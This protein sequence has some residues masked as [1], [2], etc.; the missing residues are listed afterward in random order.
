VKNLLR[1]WFTAADPVG[2]RAY[3][4]HGLAL[5]LVKYAV[6]AALIWAFAHVFWTPI[7]YVAA[8]LSLERSKLANVP[9]PLQLTLALWTAPFFWVGLTLS[10]RRARDAGV[11]PWIAQLFFVP[12]VN[13][14]FMAAMCL[15]PSRAG[16]IAGREADVRAEESDMKSRWRA[17]G[18]G[19]LAGLATVL[20]GIGVARSYGA[21]LFFGAPFVIG[22]VSAY[23]YNRA[24][25]ATTRETQE[26]VFLTL[27]LIA[28]A[29]LAFAIEG[30]LCAA[31]AFPFAYLIATMGAWFGRWIALN[32]TGSPSRAL[33][34]ALL[35]PAAAPLMDT[36]RAPA[37]YEV[38]SVVEVDA[39]PMAVWNHVVAFPRLPAPSDLIFRVGIAY[40]IG[41]RIVGAGIGA[42]R[43]CDFSTGSFVEPVTPWEPGARLSFDITSNPPAMREWSPYSITPPHLDGYFRATRGEF[44]LVPLENGRTR[45][46]GSTWYALDIAPAPYWS[47]FATPIIER[48]HVR[49]LNHIKEVSETTMR[50]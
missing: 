22:A 20:L 49:V 5:G 48:I 40:P 35:L 14:V 36:G 18:L 50:R 12:I 24:Q 9:A 6:D 30:I 43:Y 4:E 38:R 16:S 15:A 44:R 21:F 23:T 2:R 32:D 42:M 34:G 31:M 25:L 3:I 45:L 17:I 19:A 8:G 1:F 11:T 27:A 7:D 47:L 37:V 29:I 10:A 39:P 26:V 46:E 13:Y 28:L 41:A 33:L